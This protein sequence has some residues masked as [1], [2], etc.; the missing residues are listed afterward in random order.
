ALQAGEM[1]TVLYPGVEVAMCDW[2]TKEEHLGKKMK[3]RP[4]LMIPSGARVSF[5]ARA[6]E[7]PWPGRSEY[8]AQ[9]GFEVANLVEQQ[10]RQDEA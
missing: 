9:H 8:E 6:E 10:W 1:Y 7:T 5:T 2:G 3:A 4:A